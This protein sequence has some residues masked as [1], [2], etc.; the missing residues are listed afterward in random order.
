MT[1]MGGSVLL[2]S[3]L[4]IVALMAFYRE[5]KG[6]LKENTWTFVFFLLALADME[7][8]LTLKSSKSMWYR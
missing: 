4:S 1:L 7:E 3:W 5:G 6:A 2:D 8:F